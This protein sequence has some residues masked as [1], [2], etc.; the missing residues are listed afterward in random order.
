MTLVQTIIALAHTLRLEVV[1]E[2][3]DS[4]EQAKILR[5]LRC[6]GM[7]GFLFSRPQPFDEITALLKR[8]GMG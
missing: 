8:V 2:G 6:D 1:A 4:E 5:L 3:V 7:Q